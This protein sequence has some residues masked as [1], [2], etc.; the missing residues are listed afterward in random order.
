[1]QKQQQQYSSL[2]ISNIKSKHLW[3]LQVVN[4]RL[5]N[6]EDF[7]TKIL[8]FGTTNM[9]SHKNGSANER[10]VLNG[11]LTS[12][13]FLTTEHFETSIPHLDHLLNASTSHQ[14]AHFGRWSI[15]SW[16]IIFPS[17]TS[18]GMG[19]NGFGLVNCRRRLCL[20]TKIWKTILERARDRQEKIRL[21]KYC[22]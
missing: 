7:P 16:N 21:G 4:N 9:V 11:R 10:I 2:D 6:H 8:H 1:M 14:F 22:H 5:E 17:E 12:P 15:I 3:S 18:L 20:V 13:T 19:I